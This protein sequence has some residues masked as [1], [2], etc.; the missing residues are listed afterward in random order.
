M[1]LITNG[2]IVRRLLLL[3]LDVFD[4]GELHLQAQSS[5]L[6]TDKTIQR[7]DDNNL[8]AGLAELL[9]SMPLALA[10]LSSNR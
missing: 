6:S 8:N 2:F 1:N 9:P 5:F 7:V 10:L 3:R 4:V